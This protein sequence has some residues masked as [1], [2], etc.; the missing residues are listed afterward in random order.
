[1]LFL[2]GFELYSRWVGL[3]IVLNF[4]ARRVEARG[5]AWGHVEMVRF[6]VASL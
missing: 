1:M 3:G 2:C 6:F 5:G 4:I